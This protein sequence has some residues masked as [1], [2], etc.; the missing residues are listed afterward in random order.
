M[1]AIPEFLLRKLFVPNSLK[2]T[3]DG[4][5]FELVNTF[6]PVA[7]LNLTLSADDIA[8]PVAAIT[9]IVPPQPPFHASEITP[10]HPFVLP[11][12]IAVEI[13][14]Q[15]PVPQ[16]KLTIRAETREAGILQFSIPLKGEAHNQKPRPP[17]FAGL[18]QRLRLARQISRVR[19]D[20]L[21]PRWHFA[22][23][24]NWLNDPNGLIYWQGRYHLFYQHN[25][26]EPAWGSIHWGH[27]VSTDLLHWQHL[28]IAL[29]PDPAGS[30]A[31]GCFSGCAVDDNGLPTL[32]YTGVYPEVQCLATSPSGD[33]LKWHKRPAPV[34]PAPPA[35]LSL[36]GFRDP[37]VW[38][39]NS[40]WRM[41]LGSGITGVG[42]AVL[43]YRSSDL[44]QWDY[45]GVLYQGDASIRAPIWTG[46]MW[47]CPAFFPLG[48]KWVLV[49]SVTAAEGGLYTLYYTGDYRA[50]QFIPDS[51]PQLLDYGAGGCYYAPQTFLDARGRRLI[52]G[53]LREARPAADQ[54]RAGW[55]GALSL[56]GV[57]SLGT[58]GALHCAPWEAIASLRRTHQTLSQN[59]LATQVQGSS[60]ELLI[61]VDI[62]SP[63]WSGVALLV[64][65][66]KQA[67]I[68]YDPLQSAVILDCRPAGGLITTIPFPTGLADSVNLRIFIDGSVV[69][70]FD[71]NRLLASA[72]FYP[73]NPRAMIAQCVGRAS[74]DI[75]QLEP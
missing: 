22:P 52:F 12:N 34:I 25:P 23:P 18:R 71:D 65:S 31:G 73:Q 15:S 38:S 42:G 13:Q 47:E 39:E 43:L 6:A 64:D 44:I 51:S 68:G 3:T 16:K 29:T 56:P 33:L 50:N 24:A 35:G 37:C 10:A 60:M 20:P 49:I 2:P 26:F 53:W 21:H 8:C 41:A 17:I 74:A 61:K 28:P 48:E 19:R 55:S 70:I 57:L 72:R 45:L 75:W 14:I 11:M 69:E 59:Q 9:I 40:E 5:R 46:T 67:Q 54:I 7:L 27:A 1:P 62:S 63:V 36:E 58:D 4:F 30:D 32:L 66:E